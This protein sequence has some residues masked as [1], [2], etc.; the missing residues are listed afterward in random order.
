[1]PLKVG[2]PLNN[3][4]INH[5]SPVLQHRC[6]LITILGF[7]IYSPHTFLLMCQAFL[8]P[9]GVVTGFMEQGTGC[10]SQVVR[11]EFGKR[12]PLFLNQLI[13]HRHYPVQRGTTHG[14]VRIVA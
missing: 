6:T 7:V 3:P 13:S 11:A 4:L 9:V 8:Y 2:E 5:I 1:M 10:S 12:L 14:D